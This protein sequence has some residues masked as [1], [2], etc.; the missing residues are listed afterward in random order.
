MTIAPELLVILR[1]AQCK[2]ALRLT[3]LGSQPVSASQPVS[4][5]QPDP[6]LQPVRGSRPA[7]R[8]KAALDCPVCRLRFEI[9]DGIPIM[10][11]DDATRW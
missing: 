1:C 4:G 10:L 11:I 3:E 5:A 8:S 9:R 2:G 6:A 7:Q